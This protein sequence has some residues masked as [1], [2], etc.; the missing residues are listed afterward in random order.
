M[1]SFV[2]VVCNGDI[3]KMIET[4]SERLTWFEEW[5]Y[6]FEA[7]WGRTHTRWG[8]LAA[9][10][11]ISDRKTAREIFDAKCYLVLCCRSSWPLYVSHE[12]DKFL[13]KDK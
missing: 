1:L 9:M 13:R 10:F 12:H 8:D 11:K 7:V 5:V 2:M 6:Y 3:T 4:V